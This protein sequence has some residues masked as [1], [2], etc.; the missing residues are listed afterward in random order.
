MVLNS[1]ISLAC[2]YNTAPLLSAGLL[3]WTV[4]WVFNRTFIIQ[5]NGTDVADSMGLNS[6]LYGI[7]FLSSPGN[8]TAIMVPVDLLSKISCSCRLSVQDLTAMSN[9]VQLSAIPPGKFNVQIK[10]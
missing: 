5:D 6:Y 3:D 8:S 1:T 2:I 9:T 4:E 7:E 10:R